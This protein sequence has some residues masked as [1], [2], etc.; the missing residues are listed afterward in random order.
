MAK[1][2]LLYFQLLLE[3]HHV[4]PE[5]NLS[6]VAAVHVPFFSNSCVHLQILHIEQILRMF[7]ILHGSSPRVRHNFD[8]FIHVNSSLS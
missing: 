3:K 6:P 5:G 1:E 4:C 7:Q 2:P 8:Y